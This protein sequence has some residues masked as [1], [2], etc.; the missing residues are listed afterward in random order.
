MDYNNLV[1]Y[2]EEKPYTLGMGSGLLAKR[3][4]TT[5]SEIKRAKEEIKNKN[6]KVPKILIFD[7][8]TAPMKA[9][10]WGRWKQNISLSE[11]ISEWFMICWSAK[12]LYSADVL[13]GCL[14]PEEAINEDD[15]RIVKD[16]WELI[17]E[18]DIVVTH[19]GDR[20]D[21]PKI[22]SRFIVN[23]LNPPKP[24]FSVDTCKVSKRNFGFSSN[25]LDALAEYFGFAHKLDTNFELWSKCLEGDDESLEYMRQYNMRDVTLLEE[26]YLKLRPWMVGNQHPNVG[27]YYNVSMEMCSKCGSVH[28][29]VI[30]NKFYYTTVNKYKIYRC[31][32]CGAVSRA[33]KCESKN[34]VTNI[35]IGH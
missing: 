33:R 27:N 17:N 11:T 26:V 32:H 22:N 13:S 12:W 35:N 3:L 8:E 9:Y 29:D 34:K 5:I 21:I 2:M 30:P 6:Y 25:K 28:V 19:N 10:V 14:T 18:A 16:L 20:F 4:N 7:I 31:R 1:K 23:G 15:S 24:Y